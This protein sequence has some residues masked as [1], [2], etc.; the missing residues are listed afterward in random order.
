MNYSAVLIIPAD[1]KPQADAVGA[2]MGWGEVSYTI[3]LSSDP[4]SQEI[5]HWGARADVDEQFIRWI[6]G[7][8]PLPDPAFQPIV[9]ALIFDFSPDPTVAYGEDDP[10]PPS[11]WGREHFDSALA[12]HGLKE[13]T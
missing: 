3:P 2:A 6:R 10:E 8:D 1:L 5:T 4:E 7:L 12:A 9:N 11:L 13:M